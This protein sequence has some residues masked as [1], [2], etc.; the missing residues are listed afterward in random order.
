M[1][2]KSQKK[3]LKLDRQVIRYLRKL[4]Q[5]ELRE[6]IGGNSDTDPRCSFMTACDPF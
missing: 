2:K 6:V 3:T 5:E 1:N 4:S